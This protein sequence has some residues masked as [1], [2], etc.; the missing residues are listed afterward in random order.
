MLSSGSK[1]RDRLGWFGLTIFA[2][3]LASSP[4]HAVAQR[5]LLDGEGDDWNGIAPIHVDPAGDGGSSGIDLT[6]IYVANDAEHL[7][8]YFPV[9]TDLVLQDEDDQLAL[10]IDTD[11]DPLT[12]FPQPPL[13]VELRWDFGAPGGFYFHASG[14]EPVDW[15]DIGFISAP[16]HSG[17]AFELAIDRDAVPGGIAPLFA[18]ETIALLLHDWAGGGDW[19]PNS[20]SAV[21]YTF[22]ET[23]VAPI[24]TLAIAPE[25]PSA[26]RLMTHN[27][28]QDQLFD[29]WKQL[30][31]GRLLQAIDPDIICYQEVYGHTSTDVRQVVESFLGGTWDANLVG[32]QVLVT[33]S[34]ILDYWNI[35]D[36]RGGAFLLAPL[37]A[38][39]ANLLVFNCHLSCCA[40]NDDERQTQV[41]AIMAFVRDAQT[42]GGELEL[43][44]DNPIV[45]TGDMNFVGS[46]RQLETFLTGDI[47]D[48]GTY[49]P[50][51]APDW[52]ASDL[53]DVVPRHIAHA[54][55]YSWYKPIS[56]DC[57]GRLDYIIYSDSNTEIVQDMVVQTTFLGD[58]YL[59]AY[60]LLHTDTSVASDHLPVFADLYPVGAGAVAD[61][62]RKPSRGFDL[63]RRGPH[64]SRSVVQLQLVWDAAPATPGDLAAAVFGPQGRLI[65]PL[66]IDADGMLSWRGRDAAGRRVAP[67]I[68]WIRAWRGEE[69]RSVPALWLD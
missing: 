57:P 39:N 36:G 66:A 41:D 64:P 9:G 6:D 54:L 61:D 69:V 26:V 58:A 23:P 53:S 48:N 46:V 50:D 42:P 4:A 30:A 2:V 68:Y 22:D 3:A 20:G 21:E 51:F 5:I 63:V 60:D 47:Y 67:G 8:L 49:G 62:A 33:R 56:D 35:A 45:I 12:G 43:G 34:E 15:F 24:D 52:D 13:G 29:A 28:L 40:W 11:N 25:N 17:A 44:S 65:R 59:D 27:M 19:A 55:A 32:D 18:N 16:T 14:W 10:Y 38:F 37:G 1:Y 7:Y 31:H